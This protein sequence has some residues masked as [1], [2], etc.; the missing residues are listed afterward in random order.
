MTTST[1]LVTIIGN[2][3]EWFENETR[4]SDSDEYG[5]DDINNEDKRQC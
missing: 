1:T 4:G 2:K 3:S 5:D